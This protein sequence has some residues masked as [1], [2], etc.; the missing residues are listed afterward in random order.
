MDTKIDAF[1]WKEIVSLVRVTALTPDMQALLL[2]AEMNE[3]HI[4][5]DGL[6][7]QYYATA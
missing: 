2:R 4:L 6:D 3:Q 1:E 7:K 5:R